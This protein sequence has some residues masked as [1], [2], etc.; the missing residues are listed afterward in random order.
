MIKSGLFLN[1]WSV[2]LLGLLGFVAC[3]SSQKVS[4]APEKIIPTD[5][6]LLWRISGNGLKQ[7]SYLFGTST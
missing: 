6:S 7:P 5:N 4:Y 3:K 2:L 1:K